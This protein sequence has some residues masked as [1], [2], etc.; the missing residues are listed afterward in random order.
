[1]YIIL[2]IRH[3]KPL[4]ICIPLFLNQMELRIDRSALAG[5]SGEENRV[6]KSRME[7]TL[8][9]ARV[10]LVANVRP[11]LDLQFVA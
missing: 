10:G 5:A 7:P 8:V 6:L 11:P 4:R 2:L 9:A 1:M 3:W